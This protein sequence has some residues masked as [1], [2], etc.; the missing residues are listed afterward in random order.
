MLWWSSSASLPLVKNP[1]CWVPC[2]LIVLSKRGDGPLA[3]VMQK[4]CN[5]FSLKECGFPFAEG[6]DNF[7]YEYRFK[8]KPGMSVSDFIAEIRQQPDVLLSRINFDDEND[9]D[10]L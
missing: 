2:A 3:H 1:I 8:M 6:K 7:E 10:S 5:P 4:F 9:A